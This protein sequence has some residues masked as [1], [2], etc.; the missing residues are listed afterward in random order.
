MR[1]GLGWWVLVLLLALPFFALLI[2]TMSNPLSNGG[3]LMAWVSNTLL[4]LTG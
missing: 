3:H 4:A 2:H 1:R